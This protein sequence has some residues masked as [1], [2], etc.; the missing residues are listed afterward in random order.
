[1]A[2]V[3]SYYFAAE[4]MLWVRFQSG[5]ARPA[6]EIERNA[7]VNLSGTTGIDDTPVKPKTH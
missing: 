4:G 7:I 2:Q 6:T 5:E 3:V 1:M